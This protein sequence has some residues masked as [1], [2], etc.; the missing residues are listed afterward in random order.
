MNEELKQDLAA[1]NAITQDIASEVLEDV[2]RAHPV[3][4][5][6]S[7]NDPPAPQPQPAPQVQAAQTQAQPVQTQPQGGQPASERRFAGKYLSV[8]ELE[9]GAIHQQTLI[10]NLQRELSQLRSVPTA[11]QPIQPQSTRANPVSLDTQRAE[12]LKAFEDRHQ[13]PAQELEE[14]VSI[15]TEG[16]LAQ[17]EAPKAAQAQ[18]VAYMQVNH[19]RFFD[20]QTEVTAHV[21]ANPTLESVVQREI[22][23]GNYEGAME[24]AWSNF[25]LNAGIDV[26]NRMNVN[27]AVLNQEVEQARA[28]AGLVSTQAQGV[29]QAQPDPRFIPAERLNELAEMS[30][31]GYNMPLAREVFGANLPDDVFGIQP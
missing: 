13:I 25:A 12:K 14:V 29:H 9:K 15:L 4:R 11:A 19:P 18:A 16:V 8:E 22:S 27:N 30:R 21:K 3:Q 26:H 20:F 28:D 2:S 23:R 1:M 31:A 5:P 7:L 17:H 24:T 10:T 6:R